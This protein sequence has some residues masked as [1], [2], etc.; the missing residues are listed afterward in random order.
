MRRRLAARWFKLS[1]H[2]SHALCGGRSRSESHVG[3]ELP[4][5]RILTAFE[6]GMSSMVEI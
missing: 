1:E 6:F 4:R 3:N 2:T 5:V